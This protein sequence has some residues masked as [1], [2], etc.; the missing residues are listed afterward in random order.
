MRS[1]CASYYR[2]NDGGASHITNPSGGSLIEC[3]TVTATG[4]S[5]NTTPAYIFTKYIP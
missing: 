2:N 5:T 3:Y 4:S 1:G